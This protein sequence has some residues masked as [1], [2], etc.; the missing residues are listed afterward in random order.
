MAGNGA[1]VVPPDS[2]GKNI[3]CAS[4]SAG[5]VTVYRQRVVI[6]DGTRSAN[7]AVCSA[8]SLQTI[9]TNTVTVTGQVSVTGSV[10]VSGI[11]AGTNNIGAVSIAAG[12]AKI[13][14]IGKISAA[15][16]LAAGAAN[17][18]T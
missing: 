7:F 5:G 3:D 1:V 6:S 2:T 4:L 9:V 12:T 10:A 15:V 11:G 14:F 17:I 8:G 16:A 13:G 18:G